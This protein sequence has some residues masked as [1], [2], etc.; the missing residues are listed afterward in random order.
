M[1]DDRQTPDAAESVGMF[2]RIKGMFSRA[3]REQRLQE[4][5]DKLRHRLPVPLFWLFGK[6]Q[7]GK[8]SIIKFLTGADQAE[9]GKGF[10]PC[11]RF[12][13]QYHFPT[14]EAPLVSFLDTRG[15]DEPSYDPAEDLARFNTETH[16]LIVTVKVL[17]HA[18]EHILA[19][20]RT[21]RKAQPKRPVILVLTCLHEAYPQQQHPLPYPFS[22]NGDP[23]VTEPP[24]PDGLL[25][26]IAEQRS[27]FEGLIDKVVIVD[28]TQPE[29]GFNEAN[30][31]GARL[32]EV[33]L[34]ELP[35]A[36]GQTLRS[37]DVATRE[38]QDLYARQAMPHILGYSLMAATAGAVPI[39]LVDLILLSGIQT[40][41]IY[42]LAD[43]YGQPMTAKRFLEIAA[44]LGLGMVVRQA[45]RE[46]LKLIP[47]VGPVVGSVAAGALAGASTFA[48]GKAFCYYYRVVHQGHI[49]KTEDLRRYY[50]EQLSIAEKAWSQMVVDT[51]TNKE[52]ST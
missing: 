12:S 38:L 50:K 7:T 21:L 39:P 15:L 40:R 20:L 51:A 30:Y 6:T 45:S 36:L 49:P 3:H 4:R 26:S 28:L 29:E 47:F 18:Q 42:H 43:L 52:A 23:I 32:R 17:D 33:L 9:I 19:H 14:A 37:L 5:L 22:T 24:L 16:V 27:R 35:S 34:E 13:R 8:T 48:L 11:T 2:D 31:G 44:S 41:M 46:L 25:R 10:Q 1:N